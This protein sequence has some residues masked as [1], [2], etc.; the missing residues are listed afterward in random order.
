M[1]DMESDMLM[2][3]VDGDVCDWT[4]YLWNG[5]LSMGCGGLDG[6]VDLHS[7]YGIACDHPYIYM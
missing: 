6:L 4:M 3:D 2:I 7:G 1:T 5:G